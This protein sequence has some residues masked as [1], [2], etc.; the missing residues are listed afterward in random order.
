[1][2][3]GAQAARSGLNRCPSEAESSSVWIIANFSDH[4]VFFGQAGVG[5]APASSLASATKRLSA[6]LQTHQQR[7]DPS[8]SLSPSGMARFSGEI[9]PVALRYLEGD[10]I[11]PYL[12]AL[13]ERMLTTLSSPGSPRT[14]E[15]VVSAIGATAQAARGTLL[16]YFQAIMDH[17]TGYLLT[18]REDLRA[19]QIQSVEA[20]GHLG[21]LHGQGDLSA[22]G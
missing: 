4:P 8:L 3:E 5:V 19:V 9:M 13:M 16:P 7:A 14:K 22:A 17:L 21:W 12:P 6:K 2:A 15:L 10:K 18:T 1:M 11:A 20:A